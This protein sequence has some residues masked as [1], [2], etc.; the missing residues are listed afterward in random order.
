MV[1]S[2]GQTALEA[3]GMAVYVPIRFDWRLRLTNKTFM[4]L[5]HLVVKDTA[6]PS[7]SMRNRY[8]ERLQYYGRVRFLRVVI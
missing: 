8:R 1:C 4:E 6:G 3:L 5:F 7:G 2:T